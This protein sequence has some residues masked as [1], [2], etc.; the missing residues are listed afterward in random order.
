MSPQTIARVDDAATA[1]TPPS[2][3]SQRWWC[4]MMCSGD[5]PPKVFC[6]RRAPT[7]PICILYMSAEAL[8]QGVGDETIGSPLQHVVDGHVSVVPCDGRQPH[9]ANAAGRLARESSV[10]REEKR[11][12]LIAVRPH[13]GTFKNGAN[14]RVSAPENPG[15]EEGK[16]PRSSTG[17]GRAVASVRAITQGTGGV[18]SRRTR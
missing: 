7:H 12:P 9:V 4:A 14:P 13:G 15:V 10:L 16:D 2:T 11:R 8:T 3:T 18:P 17:K 1:A 5:G 6:R